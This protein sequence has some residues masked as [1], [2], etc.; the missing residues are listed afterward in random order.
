MMENR[1]EWPIKARRRGDQSEKT[2][3]TEK[4]TGA[5]LYR[6]NS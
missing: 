4:R 1:H 5:K 6:G 2:D 3:Q